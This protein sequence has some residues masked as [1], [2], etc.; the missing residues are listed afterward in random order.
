MLDS[1]IFGAAIEDE[2]DYDPRS[3]EYWEILSAKAIFKVI[4]KIV[5]Y[6][7]PPVELELRNAPEQLRNRLLDIFSSV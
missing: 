5:L 3:F 6:G 7:C 4:G 1:N 2:D